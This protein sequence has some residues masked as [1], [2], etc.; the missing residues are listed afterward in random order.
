M[1]DVLSRSVWK[2]YGNQRHPQHG[3][4]LFHLRSLSR[5]ERPQP[6]VGQR[7]GPVPAQKL[8]AGILGE[9]EKTG[10]TGLAHQQNPGPAFP[11]GPMNQGPPSPSNS[12]PPELAAGNG[13]IPAAWS[14]QATAP[15]IGASGASSEAWE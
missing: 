2:P 5:L 1:N 12:P 4:G 11:L 10:H 3:S 13:A 9:G 15:L 14:P 8:R 7:C 6:A